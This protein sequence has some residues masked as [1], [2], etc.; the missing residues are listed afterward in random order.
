MRRPSAG[1][2]ERRVQNSPTFAWL[3]RAGLVGY[4]LL[5]LLVAALSLRVALAGQ[6]ST[7]GQGALAHL[8]RDP[9]G[10]PILFLLAGGFAVLAV[11]QAIAAAV[12]YRHLAG[13]RRLLMRA[14]AACRVATYGYLSFSTARLLVTR[15]RTSGSSPRSAS[16]GVLEQP[17]GRVVLGGAGI[18]IA[19][20]GLGLVV[21][22]VRREFLEQLDERAR[23]SSRRVPIVV[24]G[25]LGYVTKGLAFGVV[26]VLVCWA[27]LTDDPRQTGGLDQSL[28]RLVGASWGVAALAVVGGGIGCFGLYLLAR[29]RHLR[30]RTLTA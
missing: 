12:G 20:V 6:P 13:R 11:W 27:A 9:W 8:S 3:V 4:G 17:L 22:G 18:A 5:H 1:R 19:A 7:S 25:Q 16:A 14:G 2:V 10:L 24:L 23:R 21:F 29:A 30:R 15:H 28:E 26:G